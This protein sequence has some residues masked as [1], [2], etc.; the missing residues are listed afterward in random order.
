AVDP[1]SLL[2]TVDVAGGEVRAGER[3]RYPFTL[4]AESRDMLL[5]GLDAIDLTLKHRADID[6][7][8]VR[9]R[10]AR[11]WVYLGYPEP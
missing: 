4:D 8:L 10:A 7:F 6:A 9:D 5:E 1:Q 11:P 2:I 3:L